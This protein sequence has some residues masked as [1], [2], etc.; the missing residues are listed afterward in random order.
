MLRR[1]A[2]LVASDALLSSL[3]KRRPVGVICCTEAAP[4][5]T[6]SEPAVALRCS[7]DD[8]D[9]DVWA[10]VASG[11]VRSAATAP[12]AAEAADAVAV[13]A[14]GDDADGSFAWRVLEERMSAISDVL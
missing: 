5:K 7:A 14:D 3:S 10:L 13:D 4:K 8:A 12:A 9:G 11:A 1:P 6:P 2:V